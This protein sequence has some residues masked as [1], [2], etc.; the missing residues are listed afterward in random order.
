[1]KTDV[2]NILR[3]LKNQVENAFSTRV[4]REMYIN[5]NNFMYNTVYPIDTSN[6]K[7]NE[8]NVFG[9][10]FSRLKSFNDSKKEFLLILFIPVN[11]DGFIIKSN[12][13]F[14]TRSLEDIKL[15]F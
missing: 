11:I 13:D 3:D 15:F 14:S 7:G 1:M 9:P 5:K 12:L 6:L 4:L 2:L 10:A 8:N